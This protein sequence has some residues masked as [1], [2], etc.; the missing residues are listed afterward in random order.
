M[1]LK[2][3]FVL[4]TALLFGCNAESSEIVGV[5]ER[6]YDGDVSSNI[7]E[8]MTISEADDGH[9]VEFFS[10][11]FNGRYR[12][13]RHALTISGNEIKVG[14]RSGLYVE[15]SDQLAFRGNEYV[16]LSEAEAE[17]IKS[18]MNATNQTYAANKEIC[19]EIQLEVNAKQSE[20][21]SM[22]NEQWNRWTDKIGERVP[23]G[24]IILGDGKR[25]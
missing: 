12:K 13:K 20:G 15:S 14:R 25:F 23:P 24:C 6:Q 7:K 16:R 9:M 18:A 2:L 21:A 3:T 5:W 11:D 4:L 1:N 8:L 22:S 10:W 17:S 19:K